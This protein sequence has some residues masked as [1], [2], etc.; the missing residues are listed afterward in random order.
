MIMF[1]HGVITQRNKTLQEKV[2]CHSRA[3][4]TKPTTY[5]LTLKTQHPVNEPHCCTLT[6]HL[7]PSLK[8]VQ[9]QYFHVSCAKMA[10]ALCSFHMLL[11]CFH[12][13]G[14]RAADQVEMDSHSWFLCTHGICS[15]CEKYRKCQPNIVE[16]VSVSVLSPA[17][18][19][20]PHQDSSRLSGVDFHTVVTECKWPGEGQETQET[21]CC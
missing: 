6:H 20:K 11:S 12:T 1:I 16:V 21:H 4:G 3:S 13:S 17:S 2:K 7:Y 18:D 9:I 19:T 14:L 8:T 10:A 15:P 5:Y